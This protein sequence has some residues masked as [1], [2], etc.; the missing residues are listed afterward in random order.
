MILEGIHAL[1]QSRIIAADEGKKRNEAGRSASRTR[2]KSLE[3]AVYTFKKG[4]D[5]KR[6][7]P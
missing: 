6:V 4:D 1:L 3:A 5:Q 2:Y 7:Y